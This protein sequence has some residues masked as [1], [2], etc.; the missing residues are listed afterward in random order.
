MK[1]WTL[2]V[3]KVGET[4][5]AYKYPGEDAE[6]TIGKFAIANITYGAGGR[7]EMVSEKNNIAGKDDWK[8]VEMIMDK[9]QLIGLKKVEEI[10]GKTAGLLN[11]NTAGSANKKAS[12][13]IRE[14]AAELGAAFVL[15]TS[16]KTDGFG[17]KQA[18]KKGI[19]YSYK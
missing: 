14:A 1:P 3:I 19:A 11:Y 2:K 10:K 6:Q 12:K 17:V 4:T 18:I 7:K 5:I 15:T 16:D 8:K 13:R 9:T